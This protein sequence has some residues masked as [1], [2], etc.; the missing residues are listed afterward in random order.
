MSR[1]RARD[2]IVAVCFVALRLFVRFHGYTPRSFRS[3]V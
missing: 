1:R 2:V 3:I